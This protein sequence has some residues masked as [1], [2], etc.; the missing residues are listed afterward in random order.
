MRDK[1]LPIFGQ[2]AKLRTGFAFTPRTLEF[3]DA[4]PACAVTPARMTKRLPKCAPVVARVDK[5]EH[6]EAN[7]SSKLIKRSRR[8]DPSFDRA[9]GV[10]DNPEL[11][12]YVGKTVGQ[13]CDG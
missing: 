5:A 3:Y 6:D 2:T 8:P 11:E 9:V 12:K 7:R 10:N 4:S 1:G 13:S